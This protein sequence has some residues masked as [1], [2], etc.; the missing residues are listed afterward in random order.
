M[1]INIKH[2]LYDKCKNFKSNTSF[3]LITHLSGS[4]YYYPNLRNMKIEAIALQVFYIITF[5]Y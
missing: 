4:Y 1:T 2:R 3:I 5:S